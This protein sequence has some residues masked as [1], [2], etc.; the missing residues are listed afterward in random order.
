[1]GPLLILI[2]IDDLSNGI[3]TICKIF[4]DDTSF[5]SKVKEKTFSD[6]QLKILFNPD[7]SKEVIQYVF[8]INA[9]TKITLHWCV[10]TLRYNLLLARNI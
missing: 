7:P 5:F 4:A 8:P 6:T 9:T 1:M 2:Y 3:E 10:M